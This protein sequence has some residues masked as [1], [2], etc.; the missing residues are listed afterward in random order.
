MKTHLAS[1]VICIDCK[2]SS[3]RLNRLG[4]QLGLMLVLLPEPCSL[5]LLFISVPLGN[6][7]LSRS[8]LR[9]I[10]AHDLLET[11]LARSLGGLCW[12]CIVVLDG[13]PCESSAFR[14]GAFAAVL[15]ACSPFCCGIHSG[16]L[17]RF[18]GWCACAFAFVEHDGCW[19]RLYSATGI[20]LLLFLFIFIF[21][22]CSIKIFFLF[23]SIIFSIGLL[24]L[25]LLLLLLLLLSLLEV[26]D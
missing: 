26:L 10:A 3:Q 22:S 18:R 8:C 6:I 2:A 17:R 9:P 21:L 20:L 5:G 25:F 23:L 1:N 16:L 11:L 15:L 19:L 4:V 12:M 7:R 24:L 13:C 14:G